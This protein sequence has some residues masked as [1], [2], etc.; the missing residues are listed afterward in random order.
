MPAGRSKEMFKTKERSGS[1][2]NQPSVLV[3]VE[4][5]GAETGSSDASVSLMP[6]GAAG[7]D[8]MEVVP[9]NC[10][11]SKSTLGPDTGCGAAP[12]GAGGA[13]SN[14]PK[15]PKLSAA[16]CPAGADGA[17]S[18]PPKLP[19]SSPDD[20]TTE[21]DGVMSNPPELPM[22]ALVRVIC[23][24]CGTVEGDVKLPNSSLHGAFDVRGAD[25]GEAK[26]S[27]T[28]TTTGGA[29]KG[30]SAAEGGTAEEAVGGCTRRGPRAADCAAD[31]S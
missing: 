21:G 4:T 23:G 28:G 20:C 26:E 7:A 6:N 8:S 10:D 13:E 19:N 3:G 11:K 30:V 1:L 16:D 25:G 18:N 22:P 5:V 17:E 31:G 14:P 2:A 27:S 29:S 24:A 15:L 12:V 9:T